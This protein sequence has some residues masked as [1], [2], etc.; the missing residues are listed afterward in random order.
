M[1]LVLVLAL[2]GLE[3]FLGLDSS[4]PKL[5]LPTSLLISLCIDTSQ[6]II[7]VGLSKARYS[8]WW[9]NKSP[10]AFAVLQPTA[11][12]KILAW[13]VGVSMSSVWYVL[14]ENKGWVA[15]KEFG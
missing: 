7:L 5:L 14:I 4:K 11:Y 12:R 10:M 13:S 1:F 15:N 6:S 2:P 3:E 9:W 8:S